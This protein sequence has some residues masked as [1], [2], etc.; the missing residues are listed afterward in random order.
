MTKQRNDNNG[1][2]FS[3][4][5]RIQ[6]PL[7]SSK[8]FLATDIDYF[9]QDENDNFMLIEEKRYMNEIKPWQKK[10]LLR[11]DKLCKADNKYK[12]FHFLQFEKTNPEDGK[13]Y[14]DKKEITKD[15]LINI[16]RFDVKEATDY[17]WDEV[18]Q[19]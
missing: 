18:F 3:L 2:E 1:T 10:I 6:E 14:W 16:L 15:E 7:K 8:G 4:W 12:G 5:L 19:R 9:W 17:E 13:I 11:L